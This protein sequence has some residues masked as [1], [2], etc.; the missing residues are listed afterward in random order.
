MHLTAAERN[1]YAID[2]FVLRERAFSDTELAVLRDAAETAVAQVKGASRAADARPEFRLPG[3]RRFQ[4]AS[5][6]LVQWEWSDDS[7]EIRL[8]EPFAHLDPVFEAL[9]RD[10]RF[11][12]P[13]RDV[14]GGEVC[15]FTDKLNLKRPREGSPFPWHQDYPYWYVRTPAHA[16]EVVTA[17]L[18]LDGADRGNGALRVLPGSQRGGPFPRD[19]AEATGF[20]ADPTR[21]DD[22]RERVVEAPAGSVLFFGAWLLHRSAP[23]HSG[24]ERRAILLSFQPAGRPRQETLPW[25]P[26]L[27]N[28]LP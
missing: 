1:N 12:A 17:M 7:A 22:A 18:F 24:R 4:L 11:L 21:I 14:F 19:R 25:R 5:D 8:L 10:E 28:E 3:D 2:G 6:S 26:R 27:V 16:H 13:M 20:L 23:N 15:A 9:L